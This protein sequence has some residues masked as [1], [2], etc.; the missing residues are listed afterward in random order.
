V[1]FFSFSSKQPLVCRLTFFYSQVLRVWPRRSHVRRT[2]RGKGPEE[3]V[4]C[5]RG[6]GTC[7]GVG[8]GWRQGGAGGT[9]AL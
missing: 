4:S 9:T 3:A 6:E 5:E 1:L 7:T 2:P 8:F